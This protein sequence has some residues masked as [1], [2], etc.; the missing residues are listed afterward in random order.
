[1]YELWTLASYLISKSLIFFLYEV[2]VL[3]VSRNKLD[4]KLN[5]QYLAH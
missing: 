4:N 2:I 5:V 3:I 1:M